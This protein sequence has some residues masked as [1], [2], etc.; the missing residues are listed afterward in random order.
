M[1]ERAGWLV[2]MRTGRCCVGSIRAYRI[3]AVP[4]AIWAPFVTGVLMLLA[5]GLG[6]AFAQPWLFPSLAT[7]A[8]LQAELPELPAA[9]F[10]NTIAGHAIALGAGFLAVGVL[11][12]DAAPIVLSAHVLTGV[13][14]WATALGLALTTLGVILARAANPAAGATALLVTLGAFHTT[15]DA[16]TLVIGVSIVAIGGEALRRLRVAGLRQAR[17]GQEQAQQG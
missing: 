3:G 16:L 5:G 2:S 7:T 14:V 13:R 11:H 17:A 12:A 1:L 9:R 8:S 6:L 4:K 15:H 10:Y